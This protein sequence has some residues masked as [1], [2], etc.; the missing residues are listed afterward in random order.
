ML[1]TKHTRHPGILFASESRG[2]N[3]LY[4]IKTLIAL[5][6]SALATVVEYFLFKKYGQALGSLSRK[7]VLL[8]MPDADL[9]PLVLQLGG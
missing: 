9:Y 7:G 6:L 1:D 2:D 5:V 4:V 8:I 3:Y